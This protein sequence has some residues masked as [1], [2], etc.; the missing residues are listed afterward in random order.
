MDNWLLAT[1][2]ALIVLVG[3]L[4]YALRSIRVHSPG[5][6]RDWVKNPGYRE[7]VAAFFE[8]RDAI[9]VPD[10]IADAAIEA[11][12]ERLFEKENR[13]FNFERLQKFG[14]RALPPVT[15]D[16]TIKSRVGRYH[17]SHGSPPRWCSTCAV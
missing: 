14:E 6:F 16:F 15:C 7:A 9:E 13:D 10:D 5:G 11:M 2:A 8:A 3:G 17:V 1:V 12:V 4:I